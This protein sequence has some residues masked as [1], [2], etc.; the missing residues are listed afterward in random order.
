MCLEVIPNESLEELTAV[1]KLAFWYVCGLAL[2]SLIYKTQV[3]GRQSRSPRV[4]S[5][6]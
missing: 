3:L 2:G 4:D 5:Q 1:I 6:H